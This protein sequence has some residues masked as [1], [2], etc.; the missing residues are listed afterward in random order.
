VNI[1]MEIDDEEIE[2]AARELQPMLEKERRRSLQWYYD[3]GRIVAKHYFA[4]ERERKR[5][6]NTMYGER[7]FER[8]AHRLNIERWE[9]LRNCF[10]LVNTYD[11]DEY[12]EL[13]QHDH[14]TVSH[15]MQLAKIGPE[16]ARSELQTAVINEQM[17]VKELVQAAK[18]KFGYQHQPGAG[19]PLKLPKSVKSAV[20]HM[21]AQA[22]KF[23]KLNRNAW[24]GNA[25]D[26]REEVRR[27]P[28]DKL[29]DELKESISEA[30]DAFDQ[31]AETTVQKAGVLRQVVA[32]IERR[33]QSQAELGRQ[34]QQE[35]EELEPCAVG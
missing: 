3:L 2:P 6:G 26:L 24:F 19:R 27:T 5:V 12:R 15:I 10:G 30:A 21:V 16:D 20:T 8:L 34:A 11:E 22:T 25:F 31:L 9:V 32:D 33:M 23:V 29:T 17:T 1:A 35:A 18:E 14:V 28:A 4:V 13:C 7:F